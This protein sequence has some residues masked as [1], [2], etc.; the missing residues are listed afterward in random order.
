M[1]PTSENA[2]KTWAIVELFG[3]GVLA[4][5]VTEQVI[6]GQGFIR[7]DVPAVKD[8]PEYSRLFGPS[9]IYSIT[10]CS[11]EVATAYAVNLRA[12]PIQIYQ[13]A[14]PNTSYSEREE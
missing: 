9:A 4:G 14:L 12:R 10:P 3:H 5:M 2:F 7:V 11:E 8:V 13:L 1:P 6:A